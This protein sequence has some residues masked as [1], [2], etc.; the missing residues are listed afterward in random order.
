MRAM[1]LDPRIASVREGRQVWHH[2]NVPLFPERA[3]HRHE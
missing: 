1:V 3:N 2:R